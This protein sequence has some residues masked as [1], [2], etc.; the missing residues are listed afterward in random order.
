MLPLPTERGFLIDCDETLHA[1][2]A[3]SRLFETRQPLLLLGPQ[4]SGK[5]ALASA[6]HQQVEGAQGLSPLSLDLTSVSACGLAALLFGQ[7]AK[8]RANQLGFLERAEGTTLLLSGIERLAPALEARLDLAITEGAFERVGG[9]AEVRLRGRVVLLGR[10]GQADGVGALLGHSLR[11]RVLTLEPLSK[12]GD[13]A[14][15]RLCHHFL[16]AR[17]APLQPL[18]PLLTG[19]ALLCL[20]RYGWPGNVGELRRCVDASALIA[21]HTIKPQDLPRGLRDISTPRSLLE[22]TGEESP[23]EDLPSLD[24]LE[25]RYIAHLLAA[26]GGSRSATARRLGIGRNTL[27]SKLRRY[28]LGL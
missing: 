18:Q 26:Y 16:L 20:Q 4:G 9:G 24:E 25:A 12:R 2:R 3:G 17:R 15:E 11:R 23:F 22:S 19:E 6:L 28:R 27:L 14:I 8:G 7:Y 1:V 5:R 10:G 13:D 21:D